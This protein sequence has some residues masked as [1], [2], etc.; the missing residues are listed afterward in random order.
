MKKTL[1]FLSFLIY[2]G[3][4]AQI[5]SYY[6]S[7]D[8][9]KSGDE[10]KSQMTDLITTTHTYEL[11]YTTTSTPGSPYGCYKTDVWTVLKK[12]DLDPD[13]PEQNTVLLT[14]GRTDET[15]DTR[16][17]RT[18]SVDLSCHTSSC[19]GKW[20]REHTFA[21]SLAVPKLT[22][23]YP[24]SGTDAHNLRAVDQQYN[25]SRG[26]N[27]FVDGSGYSG[28][29]S[30]GF[31]PGD[32]WKGSVA[33]I[34]MYMAVR[35]PSQCGANATA[36]STNTYSSTMPDLYLKWNAEQAPS[37]FEQLRNEV[38]YSYQGNRNPFIDNPYIATLIWGGPKALDTWGVLKVDDIV[39][40]Y[41]Q[42]TVY[43]TVTSDNFVYVKGDNLNTIQVY[44]YTG[45]LMVI[46]NNLNDGIIPLPNATGIYIIKIISNQGKA[47]TYK[48]IRK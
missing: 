23:D 1:L 2:I 9:T 33:R 43:P 48:V 10:L 21:K 18:R 46:D 16:Y 36:L 40:P 41:I 7:V 8:F 32:E 24:G 30:G 37:V 31:Y 34:I 12:A 47:S 4:I 26:N 27:L 5:P 11:C 44:S 28:N 3:S 14:Y 39:D 29:V 15:S 13:N 6:S 19:N 42:Y 20:T 25:A 35:Y 22:T 17:Q 38:I 45:Q